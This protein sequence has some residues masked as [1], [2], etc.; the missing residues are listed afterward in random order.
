[1]GFS[2]NVLQGALGV[3]DEARSLFRSLE[4]RIRV[5]NSVDTQ[6]LWPS[7]EICT[8]ANVRSCKYQPQ[9]TLELGTTACNNDV[10]IV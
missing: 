9:N 8:K 3:V 4:R 1:M 10:V 7:L 2:F 5:G 6:A